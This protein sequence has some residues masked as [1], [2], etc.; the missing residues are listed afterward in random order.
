MAGF[1]RRLLALAIDWGA[2][3]LVTLGTFPDL[4][5]G[6]QAFSARLLGV[7][8]VEV[9][10]LTWLAGGSFGQV[11]TRLRVERVA[12][13]RL[14]LGAAV[15]RTLLLCLVIP[16]LVYDRDGRGLHDRAAGSVVVHR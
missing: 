7:F 14:S 12:G 13:G 9:A 2:S 6:S 15:V 4:E 1:G 5:Y 8:A 11:V 3:T 10:V 16:A